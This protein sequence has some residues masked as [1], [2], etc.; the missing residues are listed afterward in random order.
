VV[1]ADQLMTPASL[2]DPRRRVDR[3]GRHGVPLQKT[4]IWPTA[5]KEVKE[6]QE[7]YSSGLVTNG[8]RYNKG[9]RHLVAYI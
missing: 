4:K 7:Q 2:C 5:D 6:I 1:F 8:E 3:R 9:G